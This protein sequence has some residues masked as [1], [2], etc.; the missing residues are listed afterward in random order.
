MTY[1]IL[2]K[3]IWSREGDEIE[4]FETDTLQSIAAP[5]KECVLFLGNRRSFMFFVFEDFQIFVD[6]TLRSLSAMELHFTGRALTL[7]MDDN[8]LLDTRLEKIHH[9]LPKIPVLTGDP[10]FSLHFFSIDW[11]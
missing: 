2:E 10:Y 11:F 3:F 8:E 9:L 4:V 7:K 6:F 1:C 5:L